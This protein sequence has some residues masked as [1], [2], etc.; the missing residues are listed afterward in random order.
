MNNKITF[1]EMMEASKALHKEGDKFT[2]I[3]IGPMSKNLLKAV[4]ELAKEK[5]FPVILIASRNQVDS[6][7]FGGG[8]VCGFDQKRFVETTNKIAKEVGFDGLCYFCRDHG[9]PWQRDKERNDKLPVAEAMEIAKESYLDDA[10]AGFDL[11]H[12]DPT[13]DPQYSTVV[14]LDI[15]LDRTM[16]LIEYIEAKRVELGLK[17]LAY[18]A[19]TEETLGGLIEPAAYEGFIKELFRRLNEKHLPLPLF[20]VGQTGTLTRLTSNVGHYDTKTASTLSEITKKYGTGLK[21]HNGDYLRN[22]ILLEHP[23]IDLAAMNVAPEFGLVETE[24]YLDL[25]EIEEKFVKNPA[26]LSHLG[27]ILTKYALN[28]QRWRKWMIG[29][30]RTAPVSEIAKN[31]EDVKLITHMCGHYTL[32]EKEVKEAVAKLFKNIEK[33]GLDPEFYV[34]KKIKDSIDRYIYC[35]N[36]YG[37]TTRLIKKANELK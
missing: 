7:K 1:R 27:E 23:V 12:I 28:G 8:Y 9:G 22:A 29:E 6:D 4:L 26:D 15:V 20:V 19:G 2:H 21:E 37:T 33:L 34:I 14:P 25:I 3:G 10:I 31:A 30:K 32:E 36:L 5:D 17:E 24:A 16:E 13:K 11:L 18:E 35:F